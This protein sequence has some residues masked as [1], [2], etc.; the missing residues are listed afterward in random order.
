MP[1]KQQAQEVQA[2]APTPAPQ[3]GIPDKLLALAKKYQQMF[4]G[5]LDDALNK[6]AE[7]IDKGLLPEDKP[8]ILGVPTKPG[9]M[10]EKIQDWVTSLMMLR[11]A[12]GDDKDV[13]NVVQ[14]VVDTRI[15]SIED[16]VNALLAQLSQTGENKMIEVIRNEVMGQLKPVVENMNKMAEVINKITN[17]TETKKVADTIKPLIDTLADA[18]RK[19][20][21]RLDELESRM[22]SA[23][24]AQ[25]QTSQSGSVLEE[26]QTLKKRTEEL[27]AALETLGMNVVE[28]KLTKEDV[29]RIIQERLRNIPDSELA[30]IAQERG[31][32]IVGGR[33]P[34]E[35]VE[36]IVREYYT[37]GVEEGKADKN[38]E[39]LGSLLRDGLKSLF[40]VIGP[41]LS[42]GIKNMFKNPT[43]AANTLNAVSNLA[44][45]ATA[46]SSG[47]LT[48]AAKKVTE[49]AAAAA[50]GSQ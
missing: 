43:A 45:A 27:K 5:T 3:V 16:K 10:S 8:P 9:S 50:G 29:E 18:I 38:A 26:V 40:D 48:E 11:S 4:G 15:K 23:P 41:G 37:R 46:A 14:S 28:E 20:N 22:N 6:I 42:E 44:E 35:E 19:I 24:Q 32:K 2:D 31:Y 17:D 47:N 13:V 1:T 34:Y 7:A 12:N 21:E 36:K 30:K 49:A 39:M 25:A 33:L